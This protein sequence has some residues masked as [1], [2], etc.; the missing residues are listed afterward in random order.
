MKDHCTSVAVI[1]M[2]I[3]HHAWQMITCQGHGHRRGVARASAAYV[4]NMNMNRFFPP[5]FQYHENAI[6]ITD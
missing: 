4:L 1:I 3:S 2:Y 5:C 6:W